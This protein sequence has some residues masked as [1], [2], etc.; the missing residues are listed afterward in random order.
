MILGILIGYLLAAVAV[1]LLVARRVDD[2]ARWA[3]GGSAMFTVLSVNSG[4]VVTF[5]TNF[6]ADSGGSDDSISTLL[7]DFGFVV[8]DG[9]IQLLGTAEAGST[10][11]QPFTFTAT[12]TGTL[13]I[14][15]GAMDVAQPVTASQLLVD[16]LRV[17]GKAP[18]VS[19]D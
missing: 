18:A 13:Q 15:F 6:L 12:T 16:N 19:G 11:W 2:S 7:N 8:I 4:D 3:V 10:G 5:D 1:G 9:E 14:A 17:N